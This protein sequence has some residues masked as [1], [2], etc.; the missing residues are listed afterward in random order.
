MS[1]AAT[2]HRELHHAAPEPGRYEPMNPKWLADFR[3]DAHSGL[4]S[5]IA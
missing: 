3:F 5:D 1:D 4:M 2:Q